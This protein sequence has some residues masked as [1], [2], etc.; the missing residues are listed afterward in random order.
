MAD[1]T[2]CCNFDCPLKEKCY[3]YRAIPDQYH[4]SFAFYKPAKRKFGKHDE[5]ILDCEYFW[6]VD[7][8]KDRILPL[9]VVDNRYKRTEEWSG[10]K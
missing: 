6:Q 7:V 2:M 3:R 10:L 8:I 4:Q 9:E 5:D 1:I